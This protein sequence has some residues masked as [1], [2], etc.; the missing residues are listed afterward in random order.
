MVAMGSPLHPTIAIAFLVC[1][2]YP[3]DFKPYHY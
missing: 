1:F 3:S 2:M